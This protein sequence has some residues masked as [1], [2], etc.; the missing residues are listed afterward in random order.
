MKKIAL[1]ISFIGILLN[2]LLAQEN[3]NDF[4]T[5]RFGLAVQPNISWLKIESKEF[6]S[7]GISGKFS[8]G[9][10]AEYSFA[11]NYSIASGIQ[12][13][14]TGGRVNYKTPVYFNE[15]GKIEIDG[16]NFL[17]NK[18]TYGTQYLNIPISLK[19]RTNEIGYITYFAQFGLD[20]GFKTNAKAKDTGS[21]NVKVTIPVPTPGNTTSKHNIKDDVNFFRMALNI[22]GG[23]EYNLSG[24]TSLLIGV[25]YSNGFVNVLKKESSQIKL[26]DINSP[27]GLG[28]ELKQNARSHFV[29]LTIGIL[30]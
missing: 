11:K 19:M 18:R 3:D 1:L 5:F 24:S 12:I 8:Y 10:L 4:K 7:N 16:S 28:S 30:F 26:P 6:E 13:L 15:S 20:A 21:D 17:L 25:N 27:F 23:I 9:L 2:G 14:T 22:G 29:G